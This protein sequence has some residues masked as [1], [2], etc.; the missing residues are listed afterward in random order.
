MY[1]SR[2]RKAI[3]KPSLARVFKTRAHVGYNL[4]KAVLLCSRV[5]L[6]FARLVWRRIFRPFERINDR[7][8]QDR[9]P[10]DSFEWWDEER[11]IFHQDSIGKKHSIRSV[12][13]YFPRG[14][15]SPCRGNNAVFLGARSIQPR[16]PDEGF[17]HDLFPLPW[18]NSKGR[19]GE[20]KK[21]RTRSSYRYPDGTANFDESFSNGGAKP[22]LSLSSVL[23]TLCARLLSAR[24][25]GE[26]YKSSS[27]FVRGGCRV[28]KCPFVNQKTLS[29][30]S[31]SLFSLREASSNRTPDTFS[32]YLDLRELL[33][34][35]GK[36]V[37]RAMQPDTE[38]YFSYIIARNG[39]KV[40]L[41]FWG[42]RDLRGSIDF[43]MIFFLTKFDRIF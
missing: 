5:Y 42:R 35:L 12:D 28:D 43:S 7:P 39:I 27:S 1:P 38:Y 18:L 8:S 15:P 10:D 41:K 22:A 19:E 21:R 23:G 30:L 13:F 14:L 16:F 9:S 25:T 17:A 20:R 37:A 33:F 3:K 24:A 36:N 2:W 40:L 26:C 11:G 31:L 4:I 32:F 34:A 6:K 29:F